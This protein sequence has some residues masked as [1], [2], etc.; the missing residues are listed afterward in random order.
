[1][2]CEH[3]LPELDAYLLGDLPP[4]ERLEI[5]RHLSTCPACAGEAAAM[6]DVGERLSR[7]LKEWVDEGVCPSD[8]LACIEGRLRSQQKRPWYMAWPMY[9][10]AI[11]AAAVLVLMVSGKTGLPDHLASIPLVG[12]VAAQLF[13]P[14]TGLMDDAI[15]INASVERTGITFTV[16]QFHTT[17]TGT[18]IRYSLRGEGLD[19][20]AA[21]GRYQAKLTGPRGAISSKRLTVERGTGELLVTETFATVLPGETLTLTATDLPMKAP[22]ASGIWQVSFKP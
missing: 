21:A 9:A 8:L 16:L 2:Q 18:I 20:Q 4:N 11:A 22:G 14:N 19:L 12:S 7:G 6:Q 13:A 3:V 17:K 10:S 15:D 5:E 1:M